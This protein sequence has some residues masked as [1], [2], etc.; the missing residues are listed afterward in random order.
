MFKI[1]NFILQFFKRK[2]DHVVIE[3]ISVPEKLARIAEEEWEKNIE[4][5]IHE[6]NLEITAMFDNN[7]WG[8]WLRSVEGGGCP[9]GYVRPPDPDWCGQAIA[10]FALKIKPVINKKLARKVLVSTYRLS[11]KSNW[12]ECNVPFPLI[13]NKEDIKRGDIV[14]LKWKNGKVYGDHIVLAV[15]DLKEDGTFDTIEG[16]ATGELPNGNGRGLVKQNREKTQVARIYRLNEEH[17]DQ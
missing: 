1:I 12:L 13:E 5:K 11:E 3:E 7:G 16:N 17:L 15:S 10:S 9:N 14:V 2:H 4:E 8:R 6:V